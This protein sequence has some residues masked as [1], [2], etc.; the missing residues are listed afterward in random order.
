MWYNKHKLISSR[1]EFVILVESHIKSSN[2]IHNTEPSKRLIACCYANTFFI[3]FNQIE[4]CQ[5]VLHLHDK[6]TESNETKSI[7]ELLITSFW[8][9]ALVPK[10]SFGYEFELQA[11]KR[12]RKSFP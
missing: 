12:A 9:G 5:A 7:S 4:N 6:H 8:K 2:F 1:Y 3:D 11:Q 10:L